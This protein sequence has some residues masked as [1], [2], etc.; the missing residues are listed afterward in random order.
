[1]RK[2]RTTFEIDL[3]QSAKAVFERGAVTDMSK[4]KVHGEEDTPQRPRRGSA[5]TKVYP[6]CHFWDIDKE[7]SAISY[8][9]PFPHINGPL[10]SRL[11]SK[12]R[13]LFPARAEIG[14]RHASVFVASSPWHFL[15][16]RLAQGQST[17]MKPNRVFFIS[18]NFSLFV[19][20]LADRTQPPHRDAAAP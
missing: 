20:Q 5:T 16:M 1:M 9:A 2:C 7:I 19:F 12:K 11:F 10:L 4:R 15:G 3:G 13:A 14:N 18:N 6:P 17:G 8:C